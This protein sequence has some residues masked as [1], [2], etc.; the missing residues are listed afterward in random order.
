M[1]AVVVSVAEALKEMIA[2]GTFSQEFTP[3][4]SYADWALE[5]T[6]ATPL[7]VDVV[8]VISKQKV[9][10]DDNE[11]LR[12]KAPIDIAIRQRFEADEQSEE[13]GKEG[14]VLL[15]KVD[16]LMLLTQ[17]I[18]A[19]VMPQRLP[20][21]DDAVW[22][23]TEILVAPDKEMLRTHKQFLSVIRLTFEVNEEL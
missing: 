2:A 5:F 18:F 13:V 19:S 12:Y 6:K 15:S 1:P 17:E 8:G 14:R 7:R 10:L 4:R 22:Q 9:E 21:F 23:S 16:A 3:E 20:E 11:S